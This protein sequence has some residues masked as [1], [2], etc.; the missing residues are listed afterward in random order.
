MALRFCRPAYYVEHLPDGSTYRIAVAKSGYVFSPANVTF[1]EINEDKQ[2]NF[3]GLEYPPTG[4]L[5][6]NPNPIQV[7]D[8]SGQGA[9]T[10]SWSAT[11]VTAVQVRRGA[12][13]GTLVASGG[14]SG[15]IYTSGIT[16]GTVFYLKKVTNGLP[17]TSANTL[18]TA[19]VNTTAQG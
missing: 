15:S 7:C 9:S 6:A 4:S 2:Q 17:L 19:T 16:N 14:T 8:G 10:L 3:T 5:T 1:D 18:A 12:P 13:N 11:G